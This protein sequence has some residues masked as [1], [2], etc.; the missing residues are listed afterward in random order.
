MSDVCVG[1]GARLRVK[2]EGIVVEVVFGTVVQVEDPFPFGVQVVV[3]VPVLVLV[4]VVA[5]SMGS[6][7]IAVGWIALPV[8]MFTCSIVPG[9]DVEVVEG[10]E[11]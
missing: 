3:V 4:V 6:S 7:T 5:G 2:P 11:T 8:L 1:R 9:S 10:N